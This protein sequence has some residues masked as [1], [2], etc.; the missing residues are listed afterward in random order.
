MQSR[1]ELIR[2]C[3]E[4]S[5]DPEGKSIDEMNEILIEETNKRFGGYRKYKL[6]ADNL[7]EDLKRYLIEQRNF[8]ILDKKGDSYDYKGERIK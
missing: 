5:I 8:Q 6:P 7:S 3:K 1:A 2:V 4:L